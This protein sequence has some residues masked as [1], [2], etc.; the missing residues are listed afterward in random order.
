[1][2]K[3]LLKIKPRPDKKVSEYLAEY[4]SGKSRVPYG[5]FDK[6]YEIHNRYRRAGR[7]SGSM[8]PGEYAEEFVVDARAGLDFTD[9]SKGSTVA[10]VGSGGGYPGIPWRI[11]RPDLNITLIERNAR[12][13]EYLRGVVRELDLTG[14]K[15]IE[16][17]AE[18]VTGR[19]DVVTAKGL[20]I[21]ALP[22]MSEL[23]AVAGR[24]VFFCSA[25]EHPAMNTGPLTLE[26]TADY[27]LPHRRANRKIAVYTFGNVSR[28]TSRR[29]H[30]K[31]GEHF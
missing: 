27:A 18:E 22:V 14:V 31:T 28:E 7:L 17:R 2:D 13:A 24:I 21:K 3:A 4:F 11:F 1:M 10:D 30:K 25:G 12:K 20:G 6:L 5:A 23:L 26:K 16:A 19:F 9:I 29:P 8:G 15:I